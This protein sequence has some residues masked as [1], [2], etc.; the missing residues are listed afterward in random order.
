MVKAVRGKYEGTR[1]GLAYS[2]MHQRCVRA[3]LEQA[4]A[5]GAEKFCAANICELIWAGCYR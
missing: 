2:A 3:K 4:R 1:A 5:T